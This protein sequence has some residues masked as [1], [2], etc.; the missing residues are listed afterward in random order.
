M[1]FIPVLVQVNGS[2]VAAQ[3]LNGK[4]KSGFLRK[5]KK[6]LLYHGFANIQAPGVCSFRLG[7]LLLKIGI[8]LIKCHELADSIG[9]HCYVNLLDLPLK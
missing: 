4:G 6:K 2:L 7:K 8:G 9:I 5:R 1:L 3:I